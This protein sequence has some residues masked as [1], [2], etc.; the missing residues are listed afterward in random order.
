MVNIPYNKIT[1][2]GKIMAPEISRFYGIKLTMRFPSKEHNPPHIHAAY[3]GYNA[4]FAIEDGT[5]LDGKFPKRGTK[6][7]VT[8]IERNKKELMEMWKNGNY[9]KLPPIR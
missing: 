8:F 2:G 5:I 6:M 4:S 7:V 1:K 9:K 3:A